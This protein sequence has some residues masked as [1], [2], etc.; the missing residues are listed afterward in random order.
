MG[1]QKVKKVS[2]MNTNKFIEAGSVYFIGNIFNKGIAF[3]TVPIFTRI[4]STYD[5]GIINTYSSWVSILTIILGMTLYMSIRAAFID[6]QDEI[7]DFL[8]A[9]TTLTIISSFTISI[10]VIIGSKLINV[11][12]S[13]WL[14][15]LC[16]IQGYS[17]AII[18]NYSMYLMMKFDYLKRTILMVVPNVISTAVTLVLL[19]Y[20]FQRNRYFAKIVPTSLVYFIVSLVV[21]LAIWKKSHKLINFMY[22]K[23]AIKISFPTIFHGLSLIIL[24]QSD[25]IMLTSMIGATETGVYSLVY[26]F[27][28][29]ASIFI[30]AAEGIWIPW[31]TKKMMERSIKEINKNVVVYIDIISTIIV[32]IMLVSPEVLRILAPSTYWHGEV[33][34]PII[35][36][37]NFIIFLYS[38]Y[39]NIEH[40]HKNTKHIAINTLVAAVLNIVL[41][42]LL[43]P[44]YGMIGA[45]FT[46][47]ISYTVSLVLHYLYSRKLEREL[48][49]FRNM[50][51]YIFLLIITSVVFYA[52]IDHIIYRYLYITAIVLLQLYYHKTLIIEWIKTK[53]V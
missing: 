29:L 5:Y 45:A 16:V 38:L 43:L 27:S 49:M 37:S 11:N 28:M 8:S 44:Y 7:D 1:S 15:V 46:T 35:I 24:A 3:L 12:L 36:M 39:V 13:I 2:K 51:K 18:N 6:H 30:A 48:F 23:Y 20:Y 47:L 17:T 40:F 50:V 10:L 53:L 19:L 26:N 31:F 42:Y 41:N 9:I 14:V 22:W 21:L 33:I 25:R 4:L 34:I 52:L 32:G